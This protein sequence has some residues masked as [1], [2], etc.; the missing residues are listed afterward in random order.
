LDFARKNMVV[1]LGQQI[2]HLFIKDACVIK[3]ICI[4]LAENLSLQEI[5]S[6]RQKIEER[7]HEYQT[8]KLGAEIMH[9]NLKLAWN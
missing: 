4:R 7:L 5:T 8:K 9:S 1:L 6:I 3:L 2:E